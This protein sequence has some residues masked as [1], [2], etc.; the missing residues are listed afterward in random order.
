[1]T[2]CVKRVCVLLE[3]GGCVK[4]SNGVGKVPWGYGLVIVVLLGWRTSLLGARTLLG[5]PGIATSNKKLLK[6]IA[7]LRFA[8]KFPAEAHCVSPLMHFSPASPMS[9]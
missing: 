9:L 4:G 5:A 3:Q 2:I 1:M 7:T 6:G 8:C